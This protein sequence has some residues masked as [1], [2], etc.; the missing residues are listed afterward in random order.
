MILVVYDPQ[1][2]NRRH[3]F[4]VYHR[5]CLR[6]VGFDENYKSFF[7]FNWALSINSFLCLCMQ[8]LL[9]YFTIVSFFVVFS[10][11]I[12]IKTINKRMKKYPPV[13]VVMLGFAERDPSRWRYTQQRETLMMTE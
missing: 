7:L 1:D 9:F 8:L 11:L 2:H 4:S 6:Q 10:I 3:E 12:L 5:G 13:M